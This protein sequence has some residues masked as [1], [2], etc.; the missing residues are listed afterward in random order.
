MM[1][2]LSFLSFNMSGSIGPLLAE[3]IGRHFQRILKMP[4]LKLIVVAHIHDN[5]PGVL[6]QL[7]K[8]LGIH[9]L[10]LP[11]HVKSRV[12]DTIGYYLSLTFIFS[13]QKDFPSSSTAI[14]NLSSCI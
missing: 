5:G 3:G 10:P 12:P 6:R 8:G 2:L 4:D 14:L 11:A 9:I 7:I 1:I 13:T